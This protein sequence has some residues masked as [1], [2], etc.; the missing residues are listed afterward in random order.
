M[1]AILRYINCTLKTLPVYEPE[2]LLIGHLN[3]DKQSRLITRSGPM[4]F[5]QVLMQFIQFSIYVNNFGYWD[6]VVPLDASA[7]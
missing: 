3:A 2:Q 5:I 6:N 1:T 7:S 4:L